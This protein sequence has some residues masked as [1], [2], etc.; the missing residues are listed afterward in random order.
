MTIKTTESDGKHT[1]RAQTERSFKPE[2]IP[3]QILLD[4]FGSQIA[5]LI[6][7]AMRSRTW[8]HGVS[9]SGELTRIIRDREP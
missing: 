2:E 6:R 7:T 3:P 9:G 8:N 5:P 4:A 1:N